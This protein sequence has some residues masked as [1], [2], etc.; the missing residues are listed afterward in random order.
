MAAMFAIT[1]RPK[2]PNDAIDYR[3]TA[4]KA[5]EIA[6]SAIPRSDRFAYVIAAPVEGFRSWN[7][8][9][10]REEGGAPG[11]FDEIAATWLRRNGMSVRDLLD[12]FRHRVEAGPWV[13][14]FFTPLKKEEIFVEVDPRTSRVVS[15]H[16]YQDEANPGRTLPQD[17]A[18]ALARRAFGT[19]GLDERAF[20]LKETLSF[21]QPRRR[22]WLFHFDER[23]PIAPN[24]FRRVTVRV[25]GGAVTQFNKTQ[26]AGQRLSRATSRRC[27]TSSSRHEDRRIVALLALVITV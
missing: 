7:A 17:A 18:L 9:S 26:G 19:F 14:R 24:A 16:R 21:Q 23:T 8:G 5:K 12:V 22:D 13:V 11:E 25:G 10:G 1:G 20:D 3:I 27:S 4:D 15:Y 6:R 2:S